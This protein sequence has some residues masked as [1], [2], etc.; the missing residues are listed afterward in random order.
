MDIM[1]NMKAMGNI[2]GTQIITTLLN[3]SRSSACIWISGSPVPAN[4]H[5][6]GDWQLKQPVV[7]A[8]FSRPPARA[9]GPTSFFPGVSP[10]AGV[11]CSSV[12]SSR[13]GCQPAVELVATDAGQ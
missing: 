13:S 1:R 4:S 9:V 10:T 3:R 11:G 8:L 6:S 12:F 2:K 5:S 7:M